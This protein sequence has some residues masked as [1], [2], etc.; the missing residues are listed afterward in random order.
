[1]SSGRTRFCAVRLT[2]V[3][4]ARGSVLGVF[5]RQIQHGSTITVT[6]P[7]VARYFLTL[8]EVSGLV[9]QAAAMAQGGEIFILDVGEETRIGDLAERLS[10]AYD[11]TRE[12]PIT[13]T[14]LRQGEKLRE[15]LIG[16]QERLVPTGHPKVFVAASAMHFSGAELR[17]GIRELEVDRRR[18]A[19]NLPARLHALARL[20][21]AAVPDPDA[22]PV[23][24]PQ[25][26]L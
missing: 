12:P 6:D 11:P 10:R 1:M 5:T 8:K 21:R 23:E 13:Y 24:A 2:N 3:I 9:I 14:G 4:D 19:G 26:D 25:G 15:D 16:Q 22:G 7:K 20:D 17:A 18:H